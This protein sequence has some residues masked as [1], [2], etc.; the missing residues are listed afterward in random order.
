MDV[1]VDVG[2]VLPLQVPKLGWHPVAQYAAVVPLFTVKHT[3][4]HAM[5]PDL[6]ETIL[7]ATLSWLTGVFIGSS[8]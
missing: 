7:T 1:E 6:P 4:W 5:Q 8:T 3:D 2:G